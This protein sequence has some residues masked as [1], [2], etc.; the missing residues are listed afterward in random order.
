[1]HKFNNHVLQ[2]AHSKNQHFNI[3]NPFYVSGLTDPPDM[4]L[5]AS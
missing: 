4:L 5:I 3:V 1:M 2:L